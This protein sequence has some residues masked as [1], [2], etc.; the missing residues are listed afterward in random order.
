[1]P[2]KLHPW[3]HPTIPITPIPVPMSLPIPVVDL[4]SRHPWPLAVPP[5]DRIWSY[6]NIKHI[7]KPLLYW[8]PSPTNKPTSKLVQAVHNQKLLILILIH[9]LIPIKSTFPSL[10]GLISY[11]APH[12]PMKSHTLWRSPP[13][14]PHLIMVHIPINGRLFV[15][16]RRLTRCCV[17]WRHLRR[18]IKSVMSPL[19]PH[20]P[21]M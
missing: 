9:L 13:P 6:S 3:L 20:L 19:I 4:P 10:V 14:C 1:M 2:R 5:T 15:L 16:D 12:V 17:Y 8:T 11:T 18:D 7:Y 21:P